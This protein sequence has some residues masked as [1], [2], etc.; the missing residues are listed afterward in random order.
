MKSL[1]TLLVAVVIALSFS[2]AG[3]AA[4]EK[5]VGTDHM[6]TM[7][8][9]MVYSGKVVSVNDTD[10]TIVVK[11]KDGDKTFDVSKVNEKVLP[12]HDVSVTYRDENGKMVASSVNGGVKTSGN[13]EKNAKM[14]T[15]RGEVKSFDKAK[16]EL[17]VNRKT[18][19]LSGAKINGVI[20]PGEKVLVTYYDENGDLIATSVVNSAVKL[21]KKEGEKTSM[22]H[23]TYNKKQGA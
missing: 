16:H 10:H 8:Q 9:D 20:N 7:G 4:T 19:D 5:S 23:E 21:G 14:K 17:V 1:F 12:G 6:T 15:Y 2:V 13:Y 3:F 18:F 11:G 22:K